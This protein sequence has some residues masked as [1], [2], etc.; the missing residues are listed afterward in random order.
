VPTYDYVC[1]NC[2]RRLEVVHSIHGHGPTECASCGGPM[3]KAF[4]APA[5]HFKGTGW[6][7]KESSGRGRSRG[8]APDYT[9]S[10]GSSS[11][12][13]S[14]N[15][16]GESDST[17]SKTPAATEPTSAKSDTTA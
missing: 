9:D 13:D 2:G 3:K 7:R 6:A 12:S 14:S 15:S 16:S 5:I 10:S 17:G 11:S 8:N 4:S 1:E